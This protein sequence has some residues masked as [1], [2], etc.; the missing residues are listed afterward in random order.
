M[1]TTADGAPLQAID[2]LSEMLES[3]LPPAP[4]AQTQQ[5]AP[6]VTRL[7][8]KTLEDGLL[9]DYRAAVAEQIDDLYSIEHGI[10]LEIER[11]MRERNARAIAHPSFEKIEL[12]EQFTSYMFDKDALSEA[13]AIFKTLGKDDEAA[14][15]IKHVPEQTTVVPAHYEPGKAVS[16][17]AL[18]EKYGSTPGVGEALARALSR[19]SLGTKL[20]V[21]RKAVR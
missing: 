14:K 19:Q 15:L 9:L 13:A 21:K 1:T 12:E 18:R 6:T 5:T 11:R 8:I 17:L 7:D 3:Q 4:I 2:V 10:D 20:I 16:I